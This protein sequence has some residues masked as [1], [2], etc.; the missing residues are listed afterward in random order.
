[1]SSTDD[2]QPESLP[3][4]FK[5]FIDRYPE[6]GQAHQ[7][8]GRAAEAAGPLD[9]KTIELIKVGLSIGAGLETATR[10]H[11][12]QAMQHGATEAEVEQ[13]ALLAYNTCGWPRMVM[14]WTWVRHQL[15]RANH[16]SR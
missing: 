1:M 9:R 2:A 8:I 10:S 13:V 15:E 16:P 5:D 12:R 6:L 7:A 11:V 4:R 14:A 3:G